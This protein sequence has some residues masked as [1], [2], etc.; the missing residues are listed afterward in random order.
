MHTS[1]E[2]L[3]QVPAASAREEL[4]S[5]LSAR[6]R[7]PLIVFF[8]RRTGLDSEAEDM[9]Q[10]V[11]LRVMQRHDRQ[12]L[13]EPDPFIFETAR[14]LLKDRA[15]HAKVVDR[16]EA[17]IE[18][19]HERAEHVGPD[20]VLAGKQELARVMAALGE[21]SE[22]TRDIFVMGRL[23]GVKHRE[24]A[25]MYGIS[26]K[27]IEKHMGKALAHIMNQLSEP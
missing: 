1:G 9:A 11:L 12:P 22:Q 26:V 2:N 4:R 7:L 10:E 14:N 8:R 3:R 20:R 25:Q 5:A 15:R 27:A 21:L 24:I 6:F 16:S 17:E 13:T 19:R 18:F 23:E